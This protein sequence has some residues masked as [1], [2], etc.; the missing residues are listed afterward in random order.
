MKESKET[1]IVQKGVKRIGRIVERAQL[2]RDEAPYDY[3]PKKTG[4]R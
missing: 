4:G 3:G 2:R 1:R